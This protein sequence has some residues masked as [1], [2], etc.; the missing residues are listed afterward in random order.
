M[1]FLIAGESFLVAGEGF[2]VAGK[3]LISFSIFGKRL[4]YLEGCFS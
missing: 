2:L 3:G 1:C 4:P